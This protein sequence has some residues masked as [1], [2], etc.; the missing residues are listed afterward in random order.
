MHDA[1]ALVKAL[2]GRCMVKTVDI[3]PKGHIRIQTGFLYPDGSSVD[4]FIVNDPR[5]PLL[6][7]SKLSDLGQTMAF[8]LNHDVKPWSSKK[9][10]VQLEEAVSLYGV[11]LAGGALE[12][13][14]SNTQESLS[15]AILLLGQACLRMSDFL[16][17]KRLQL[18]SIF[19]EDVEEFL[20]DA[21]LN[22]EPAVELEGPF[23]P[24][25]IDFLVFGRTTRSAVLTLFSRLPSAAHVQTNEVFRKIYDLSIANRPE[26][27]ITLLD[28]TVDVDRIYR[29][30]DL[31]RIEHHSTL[32]PF[33]DRMTVRN[34]LAA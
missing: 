22:Y 11:N 25:A 3:L 24:V 9:R 16:F 18:Q 13:P 29:A 5:E 33:S 1:A 15:Q 23:A 34:L 19:T 12:K 28:D 27:R 17:T 7:P 20:T 6:P 2:Q 31:R 21:D 10:R 4:V 26:Q 32:V 30:D 8:L 14:I